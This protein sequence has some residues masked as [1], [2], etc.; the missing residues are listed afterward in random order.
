MIQGFENNFTSSFYIVLSLLNLLFINRGLTVPLF[1]QQALL[2]PAQG[3]HHPCS[4]KRSQSVTFEHHD[5]LGNLLD[6]SG[7]YNLIRV[8]EANKMLRKPFKVLLHEAI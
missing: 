2:Q 3:D 5:D 1:Q 4:L 8:T 6:A 7:R